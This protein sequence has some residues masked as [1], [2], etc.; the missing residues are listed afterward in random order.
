MTD[1]LTCR[2]YTIKSSAFLLTTDYPFRRQF[3]QLSDR[4]I[5]M[6]RTKGFEDLQILF[7]VFLKSYGIRI[8][9]CLD[10]RHSAKIS[11]IRFRNEYRLAVSDQP[12]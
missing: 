12:K 5:R 9:V 11:S 10:E 6:L 7:S 4:S 3:L 2:L 1:K 8:G